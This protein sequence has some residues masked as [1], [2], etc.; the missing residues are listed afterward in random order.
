[1]KNYLLVILALI[2]FT[3]STNAQR[4]VEKLGRGIVA[5]NVGDGRVF[6][7]WRFLAT[8]PED[9]G[10]NVYRS[11]NG[12]A[13]TKLNLLPITTTTNFYDNTP[14]S[15]LSN[16]Y[17]VKP[18]ISGVE[19]SACK[20]F[21]IDGT[22]IANRYQAITLK[23]VSYS[24][25]TAHIY[26]GDLDGDGEYE[27][28]VQRQPANPIYNVLV[29]AY[30][31]E[32][33]FLWR[34]DL[35]RN[36]EQGSNT[37]NPFVLVYDFNCDGKAEVLTRT[38][39]LTIFADGTTIPD[40][41]ADGNT[42]YRTF[43]PVTV[44][45]FMLLGDECPEYMSM[46]E[47]KTG[48]E[49]GRTDWIDRGP[50]VNWGK[51]WG[52]MDGHRMNA[53]TLVGVAYLDGIH[54]SIVGSR[55]PG[56]NMDVQAWDFS[57]GTFTTRWK[58]SARTNATIPP[59]QTWRQFHNN[60]ISG[61]AV[62]SGRITGY[63]WHDFHNFRIV[64]VDGDGKDEIAFGVNTMDDNGKPLYYAKSDIGHGDRFVV[65]D[66]DPDRPGLEGYAIQQG[67]SS[68]AVL[69][70]AKTGSRIKTW[71][72]VPSFDVGRGDAADIDP[73]VRGCELWSW[74]HGSVLD[75]KGTAVSG[76]T[77]FP[78]PAISIWWDADLQRENFDVADKEGFSPII[79]KWNP[80]SNSTG[81]LLSLYNEGG[82]YSTRT[83]YAG[84]AALYGDI[85]G[86]WREEIFCMSADS[87]EIRIFSTWTAT[88]YKIYCLMQNPAYRACI[89]PK[90]YLP[91]TEVD[92][93]LGGGMNTPPIPP[94]LSSKTQWK[95]GLNSNSWDT[96]TSN[97]LN[98]TILKTFNSGDTVLFD[99]SGGTNNSVNLSSVVNPSQV[100]VSSPI[101][102]FFNGSG[103]IGGN[104]TLLKTGTG[105]LF[106]NTSNSYTGKT[107]VNQG[108]LFIN[109]NL[110]QSLVSV[111]REAT[112]GGN[113]TVGQTVTFEGG[114]FLS[115]GSNQSAGTLTFAKS[116]KLVDRMIYRLNM[117]DDPTNSS[118]TKPSDKVVING[119]LT[120]EGKLALQANFLNS[121]LTPGNYTVFSYTGNFIGN[122]SDISVE[123]I[124][125]N[126]YTLDSL[127]KTI[128][129][130]IEEGRAPE[131]IV[132][133]GSGTNWD[134][135][136]SPNWSLW[137]FPAMF[138]TGD[139]VIFNAEGQNNPI[140]TLKGSLSV[141]SILVDASDNDYSF[142]GT[143]S[144]I[145]TSGLT[146]TG[147]GS[148]SIATTNSY[149]GK[150][151]VNAGTLV[152]NTL[153]NKDVPSSIG[154]ANTPIELNQSRLKYPGTTQQTT[155]RGFV[156]NGTDTLDVSS[157]T[158]SL[159][160][161]GVIS[162]YGK[163]VKTGL[164][165]LIINTASTFTG[166]LVLKAGKISL[167]TDAANTSG[168]GTGI[169]SLE[170][171]TL[172]MGDNSKSYNS[173]TYNLV[174][175]AGTTSYFNADSRCDI[176]GT[177]SGSGTLVFN[178][179]WIR[180]E[181]WANWSGFTGNLNIITNADG[182]EF[183]VNNSYGYPNC[184]MN[185]GAKVSMY[186]SVAGAQTVSIGELSGN[187]AAVMSK[188]NWIIGAKNTNS[189]YDGLIS[190]NSVSKIGTGSLTLTNANTYTGGTTINGGSICLT[191]SLLGAVTVNN[192]GELTGKGSVAGNVTVASGGKISAGLPSSSVGTL[193]IGGNL[194]LQS[195]TTATFRINPITKVQDSIRVTGNAALNGT[196]QMVLL[197]GTYSEGDAFK[198]INA[199][200]F[201]G[202]F[203]KILPAIPDSNL[204]WDAS[205]LSTDGT[206]RIKASIT[207][208]GT[209]QGK[210]SIIVYPNPVLDKL[211]IQLSNTIRHANIIIETINGIKVFSS[212]AYNT[213]HLKM[214]IKS[215]ESGVYLLKLNLDNNYS[216]TKF[217]KN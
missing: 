183:R 190:G 184:A 205:T 106:L 129:L 115:P 51:L 171:G 56:E 199:A 133:A 153:A 96:N 168:L 50:K 97:W 178:T 79:E 185:L 45:N 120:L 150:T 104:S 5:V 78:K 13:A 139:T 118:G 68:L 18:V 126:K 67:S 159:V 213:S 6:L 179:P 198:I 36:I 142:T 154:S 112:L 175:A 114:A 138:A 102:Y 194:S 43:P 84:F 47:G 75:C 131:K 22:S 83:P 111:S 35:G 24:T 98:D 57:T 155:D 143:G 207:G 169:I 132:W 27:Y 64:D 55:G 202:T 166:G 182:G 71:T 37:H 62:Y 180:T 46:V 136:T 134:L 135:L 127:N 42:D 91:S 177:L 147:A 195:G 172:I 217:I 48:K 109:G 86:D 128:F 206:L 31:R 107:K 187:A 61:G 212:E 196:L 33:A 200:T 15:T 170:G 66:L 59:T 70:D 123:G 82:K 144:I 124:T 174:S 122:L 216:V 203:S 25:S 89:N 158:G 157:S 215:L 81:R 151:I 204:V 34:I 1:M 188:D 41:N 11:I 101:D 163:L 156:I 53:M 192:G 211:S 121:K 20:P 152:I 26:P 119:N 90:G 145:G 176:Y 161:T 164:G 21:K 173:G 77:S 189:T 2:S 186:H 208:I 32:G 88:S 7:S 54:P 19:G 110:S 149:T 99:I 39:E 3:I 214:D 92:Y 113:G 52:D 181:M 9:I 162:G 30:S 146:K 94:V 17:F 76:S 74:A 60:W 105:A 191:G 49:I 197:N 80:A 28:I 117:S 8:D 100:W 103:S 23:P 16:S 85:L 137:N 140:V 65:T 73:A 40:M 160:S 12:G 165:N 193:K 148:L 125:N 141:G 29:E 58:W 72:A 209:T 44:K 95:G 130:K 108:A 63:G 69:Y 116:L 210:T 167:G 201:S 14:S 38:S 93:Y 10:F 4:K 87:S